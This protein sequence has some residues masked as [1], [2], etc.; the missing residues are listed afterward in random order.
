MLWLTTSVKLLE[1]APVKAVHELVTD[2]K[3]LDDVKPWYAACPLIDEP[4]TIPPVALITTV[5]LEPLSVML[6]PD[7]AVSARSFG[8]EPV[9]P[10]RTYEA[11]TSAPPPPLEP[12]MLPANEMMNLSSAPLPGV[13]VFVIVNV[14][15]APPSVSEIPAP[16]TNAR[17]L[18]SE[19]VLPMMMYEAETSAPPA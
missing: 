12:L 5:L 6:M 3:T 15:P 11:E 14:P 18:G 17:S 1:M 7:P 8:N 4:V 16:A 9:F 19:P 13:P 2:Q 10:M